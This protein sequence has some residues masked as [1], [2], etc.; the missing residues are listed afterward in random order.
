MGRVYGI[1][2]CDCIGS[3]LPDCRSVLIEKTHMEE[4]K[5]GNHGK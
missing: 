2:N 3:D 1:R 5:S 4:F